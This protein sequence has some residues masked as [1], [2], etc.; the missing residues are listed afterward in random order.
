MEF[1]NFGHKSFVLQAKVQGFVDLLAQGHLMAN[2]CATCRK[3]LF[4]PKAFCN[5]C[6]QE[7]MEWVELSEPGKLL[8]FTTVHY[9]PSGFESETPYTLGVV[10]FANGLRMFGELNKAIPP[11]EI[12]V[13]MALRAVP[14]GLDETR[15][16]YRFDQT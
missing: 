16:S 8:T 12:K 11:E 3:P 7:A 9:G 4:P 6:G 14:V 15:F 2:Q 1:Q 5:V 13:G 10:G